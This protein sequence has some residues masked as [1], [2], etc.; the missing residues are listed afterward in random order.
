MATVVPLAKLLQ[1]E[2]SLRLET[3]ARLIFDSY[4]KDQVT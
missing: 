1:L 2:L 4:A 3:K